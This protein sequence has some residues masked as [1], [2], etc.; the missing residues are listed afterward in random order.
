MS[1]RG[2][3]LFKPA[4]EINHW[5]PWIDHSGSW[6]SGIHCWLHFQWI[7]EGFTIWQLSIY[8]CPTQAPWLLSWLALWLS[9]TSFLYT[10]PGLGSD[11]CSSLLSPE[12]ERASAFSLPVCPSHFP[13][14]VASWHSLSVERWVV[15][16][17]LNPVC[18]LHNKSWSQ[19][20]VSTPLL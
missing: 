16:L 5:R 19:R 14:I 11:L 20:N 2:P 15:L 10:A 13:G 17:V 6:M 18:W 12:L 8:D 4:Q 7:R 1:L 9:F 3:L